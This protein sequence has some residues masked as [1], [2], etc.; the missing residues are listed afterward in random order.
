MRYG[1]WREEGEDKKLPAVGARC[2]LFRCD[3]DASVG[4]VFSLPCNRILPRTPP[5]K[6]LRFVTVSVLAC[7]S[8]GINLI[9]I[10]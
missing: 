10:T 5:F 2:V 1:W 9:V 3:D 4:A 6:I 8:A 7:P